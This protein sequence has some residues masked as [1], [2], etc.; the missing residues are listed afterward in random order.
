MTFDTLTGLY[1]NSKNVTTLL[2]FT[3]T[4]H[5]RERL[6]TIS[7]HPVF[8]AELATFLDNLKDHVRVAGLSNISVT[9][10]DQ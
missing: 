5:L 9:R 8:L 4:G 3:N 1:K 7:D 2:H 6:K 10:G